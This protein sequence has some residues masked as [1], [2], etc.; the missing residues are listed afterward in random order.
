M[1]DA[2]RRSLGFARDDKGVGG[3]R[4]EWKLLAVRFTQVHW[5]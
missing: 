4:G 5:G 2:N 1:T 3:E